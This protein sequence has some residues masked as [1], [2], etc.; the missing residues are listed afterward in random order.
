ML[1]FFGGLQKKYSIAIDRISHKFLF[2][3]WKPVL[4]NNIGAH[5]STVSVYDECVVDGR[6]IE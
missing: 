2:L 6:A 4:A 5:I 3:R 1:R